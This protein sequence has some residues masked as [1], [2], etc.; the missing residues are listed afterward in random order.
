MLEAKRMEYQECCL[1]MRHYGNMRFAQLTLFF[2]LNAGLISVFVRDTRI[3]QALA[4]ALKLIGIVGSLCFCLMDFRA[5]SYWAEF[6]KRAVALEEELDLYQ[7]RNGL[8]HCGIWTASNA[9]R[10]LLGM[11]ALVWFLALA[12][13]C[14]D[15]F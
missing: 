6:R 3:D 12:D 4:F 7:Y 10:L 9:T 15:V 2:A 1:N 5:A 11:A 14:C 8:Q 13:H